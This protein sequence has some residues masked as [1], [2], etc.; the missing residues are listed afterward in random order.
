M[1]HFESRQRPHCRAGPF[2]LRLHNSRRFAVHFWGSNKL[3]SA[4]R[5]QPFPFKICL[6]KDRPLA[7]ILS[8]PRGAPCSSASLVDNYL[9][10]IFCSGLWILFN[11]PPSLP[12]FPSPFP[13][14]SLFPLL[15]LKTNSGTLGD[16]WQWS[17]SFLSWK[18]LSIQFSFSGSKTRGGHGFTSALGS[19]FI[20][21][22]YSFSSNSSAN[23]LSSEAAVPP[24]QVTNFAGF[25]DLF[26]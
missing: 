1:E 3:R 13:Y 4:R 17:L 25:T 11:L 2:K 12:P 26:Q 22:G 14:L 19:M 10:S 7:M 9:S 23:L 6:F 8:K 21:G 18:Q 15:K 24:G 20:S 16:L 5:T